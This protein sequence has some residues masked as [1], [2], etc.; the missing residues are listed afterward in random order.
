[1]TPIISVLIPVYNRGKML[2]EA[3]DSILGQ[4]FQDFKI[5][6]YDDASTDNTLTYIPKS[7]KIKIIR[8]KKNMGVAY[9]RSILL[10]AADTKYACWQDSDDVAHPDR[11]LKQINKLR[12]TK[13]DMVFCYMKF[14]RHG[15][16]Y[17]RKIAPIYK[18]DVSKY[19]TS[20]G[21]NGNNMCFATAMFD[22]ARCSR[23]KFDF[24]KR[25]GE[26]LD[27]LRRLAFGPTKA[28]FAT[29]PLALYYCRRHPGRLT[30]ARLVKKLRKSGK[31]PMENNRIKSHQ[32]IKKSKQ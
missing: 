31:N 26:D 8:G 30:Y 13:V 9:A 5:I 12:A 27:W 2:V 16:A 23:E 18:V 28:S 22:V 14:F 32:P 19:N 21:L 20:E 11:L 4:S 17:N 1:M 7:D 6:I 15:Q 24:A 29:V 10:N 3:I 25:C